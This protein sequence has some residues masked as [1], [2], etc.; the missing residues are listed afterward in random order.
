MP[1]AK[2]TTPVPQK[3]IIC[4]PETGNNKKWRISIDGRQHPSDFV[5]SRDCRIWVGVM[6]DAGLYTERPLYVRTDTGALNPTTPLYE[7]K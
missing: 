6:W 3:A 7:E 2:A 5:S 1:K 4:Y